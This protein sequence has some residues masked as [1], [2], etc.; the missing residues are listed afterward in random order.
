MRNCVTK[1]KLENIKSV[2]REEKCFLLIYYRSMNR[3]GSPNG[4][5]QNI[6][7]KLPFVLTTFEVL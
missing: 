4:L 2:E 7:P 1:T 6:K 5:L 3:C